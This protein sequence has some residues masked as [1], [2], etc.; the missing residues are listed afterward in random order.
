MGRASRGQTEPLCYHITHRCHGRDFLLKFKQDRR[1]YL[2]RLHEMSRR[3]PI[4]MLSYMVTS[5]HVHLLIWSDR[6][7]FSVDLQRVK[8]EEGN[9]QILG[10][11]RHES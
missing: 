9:W 5:N 10:R 7:S 8:V 6:A 11:V 3:F 1:N 2:L 4:D